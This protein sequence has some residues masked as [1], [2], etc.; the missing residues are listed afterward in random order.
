MK[1]IPPWSLLAYVA[2]AGTVLN[3]CV[4]WLFLGSGRLP[5]WSEGK[6]DAELCADKEEQ[7]ELDRELTPGRNRKVRGGKSQKRKRLKKEPIRKTK[8]RRRGHLGMFMT[9]VFAWL[10]HIAVL[11]PQGLGSSCKVSVSPVCSPDLAVSLAS[12][13]MG[14]FPSFLWP[15]TLPAFLFSN[16]LI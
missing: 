2:S 11:L 8:R 3:R 12:Q 6:A 15:C 13:R 16:F 7:F 14:C 9:W 10:W 1:P 4:L 5:L